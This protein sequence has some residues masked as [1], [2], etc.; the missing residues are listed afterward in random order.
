MQAY[1]T[2]GAM[3]TVMG[4][5]HGHHE[6]LGRVVREQDDNNHKATST[7]EVGRARAVGSSPSPAQ[8]CRAARS[9]SKLRSWPMPTEMVVQGAPGARYALTLHSVCA[10]QQGWCAQAWMQPGAATLTRPPLQGAS[11]GLGVHCSQGTAQPSGCCQVMTLPRELLCITR[12]I[13]PISCT[14]WHA[15]RHTRETTSLCGHR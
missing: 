3:G 1:G 11:P 14:P 6:L 8:P 10:P 13:C 5:M 2:T 9:S 15:V 4:T 12:C 7:G